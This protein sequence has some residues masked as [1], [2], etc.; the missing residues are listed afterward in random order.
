MSKLLIV[1]DLEDM[2]SII[3]AIAEAAGYECSF[4]ADGATALEQYA[5][6]KPDVVIADLTLDGM[7]GLTLIEQLNAR[8]P[9]ANVI[10]MTGSPD[11]KL[12][13]DARKAG[14]KSILIKPFRPTDM[15]EAI[16]NCLD[17]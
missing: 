6:I 5:A 4:A 15:K 12:H 2:H 11:P 13:S 9:Q 1:D 3:G 17:N 8:D 16:D 14:A 10:G 7:H